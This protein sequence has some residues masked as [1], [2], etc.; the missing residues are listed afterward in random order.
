MYPVFQPLES[1]VLFSAQKVLFIRGGSGTGGFFDG[2]TLAQR[3]E[4]LSDINNLSTKSGNHGWGELGNLLRSDNFALTEMIETG[5]KPV[6]LTKIN[7]SQYSTIVFGS[8]N[9]AYTSKEVDALVKFVFAG[10]SALFV[11]DANFGSNWG[12]APSSDQTFLTRFGLGINQD[13]DKY[14]LSRSAGDF[15]AP[16]HPILTG[17]NQFDGEGVSL[18]VRVKPV[19]GVTPEVLVRGKGQTRD[20]NNSKGGTIRNPKG[21]EGAL[22]VAEAGLGRVAITFD[23]NTFFNANGAGTNLHRFDNTRY[24]KNLFEWLAGRTAGKP[25]VQAEDFQHENTPQ[26]LR[27]AFDRNVG[28]SLSTADIKVTNKKTGTTVSIKS[29]VFDAS[30]NTAT[31]TFASKLAA[32]SYLATLVATGVSDSSGKHPAANVGYSFTVA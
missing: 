16:A 30:S 11:S 20:N 13:H 22:V 8:N 21:N 5:G 6:D 28:K 4:E 23:R 32:G 24:A 26:T 19:A 15:L 27:V 14:T 1:R 7:L 31:F 2:G 9:A 29:E 3:D 25:Q 18:G 12:A 10:G 17:V